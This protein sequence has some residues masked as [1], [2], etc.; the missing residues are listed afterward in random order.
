[1]KI[2]GAFSAASGTGALDPAT[3]LMLA[4]LASAQ[5]LR[6]RR[7]SHGNNRSHS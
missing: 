3:L 2:A 1:V 5:V 4:A 7:Q 6:R